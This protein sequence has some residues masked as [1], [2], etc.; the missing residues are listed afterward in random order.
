M[1]DSKPPI[2]ELARDIIN[3]LERLRTDLEGDA[4]DVQLTRF[5]CLNES[6]L[7][8]ALQELEESKDICLDVRYPKRIASDL[9]ELTEK[10]FKKHSEAL[11]HDLAAGV[12]N[13]KLKN[14]QWIGE[15]RTGEAV[16]SIGPCSTR[17]DLMDQA[18]KLHQT[19]E[20][21]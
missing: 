12:W 13:I 7:K 8:E 17:A 2:K 1:G 6:L 3:E 18:G 20:Q 10:F 21:G 9:N 5:Q 16:K 11:D 19:P 15:L 4:K 14:G